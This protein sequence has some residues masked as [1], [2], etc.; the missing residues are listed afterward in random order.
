MEKIQGGEL[1]AYAVY[2][3]GHVVSLDKGGQADRAGIKKGHGFYLIEVI[4]ALSEDEARGKIMKKWHDL[5]E[6]R[7]MKTDIKSIRI[8][9]ESIPVFRAVGN[10][11]EEYGILE[12]HIMEDG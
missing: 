6:K 8:S 2:A 3:N 9:D 7:G 5:D 11:E 10:P 4:V 12:R 1:R